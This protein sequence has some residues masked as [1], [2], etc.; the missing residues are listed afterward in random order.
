TLQVG[1]GGTTGTL[2]G[3][4]VVNNGALVF[5]RSN[6]LAV[7]NAISGSGSLTQAG[8]GLLTLSGGNSYG[9][10]T[11]VSGTGGLTL[12]GGSA[13]GNGSAVQVDA[14][15][16]LTIDTSETIGSL[17]GAGTV[18]LAT[19]QALSTGGNNAS[20]LFSGS[21]TGSVTVANT[22]QLI[23]QGS[24]SFTLTG[25]NS[26]AGGTSIAAG[27]SL[28]LGNGGTTGSLAGGAITNDGTLIVDRSN[29][30][31][32]AN[33]IGGSGALR[34]AGAGLL[35]L[36]ADNSYGGGTTIDTGSTLQ[37]GNGGAGG[38]AG[39][40]PID[41]DGA[42]VVNR[43]ADL[44]LASLLQGNG[45]LTQTGSGLLTLTAD[46][47]YLDTTIDSGSTL[48]V[49]AGGSTGTLGSGGITNNG[50]LVFDR[51]AAVTLAGAMTGTGALVQTGSGLLILGADNSHGGGTTIDAGSTLQVGAGGATG[52]LGSGPV[53]NQG[54]LVFDRSAALTVANT[55]SGAGTL[56]QTGS[57]SL[58]LAAD[59]SYGGGTTIDSGSVLRLGAGGTTGSAGSGAIVDNGLLVVERSSALVLGMAISGSGGL[60][61]AGTGQLTLSGSN[62]YSGLTTVERGTLRLL[63][64][65]ALADTA[66]VQLDA[67]AT[68][69]LDAN[70]TIGSLSG[71][72]GATV[73]LGLDR[74]L[75]LGGNNA[76]TVFAGSI[77]G[78]TSAPGTVQL[79]KL[80][81]GRFTLAG[82]NS[83]AGGITVADG[84]LQVGNGGTAGS[85]GSGPVG[86]NAA[87]VFDRSDAAGHVVANSITGS[88][89][90]TQAGTGRLILTG[91]NTYGGLTTVQ[92]GTTLQVGQG[93]GT[94]ALG[95]GNV[96]NQGALVFDRSTALTVSGRI[97]G[98]GT[99]TQ[100]GGGML[101]LSGSNGY[102][103][104]TTVLSGGLT[105]AGG[106]ALADSAAVQLADAA[107]ATLV[108]A[109]DETLGSLAGGGAAG[110][111]V[112]L[113]SH[114]LTLGGGTTFG[115]RIVGTGGLT[116]TGTDLL[117]LAGDSSYSGPTTIAA[118]VLQVGDGGSTGSL[119]SGSV[120]NQGLLRF[121]R[122]NALLV[123]NDISGSGGLTQAGSGTLTLA[124]ANT[125]AG[126][127]LVAAGVLATQGAE[128]LPDAGAVQV[129]NGAQ[130]QLGGN[131]AIGSLADATGQ[132]ADGSARVLLGSFTLA[133]G[134]ASD[135]RF[136]GVIDGS[137]GFT[138]TGS[139]RFTLAGLNSYTG[140]TLVAAGTLA[141]EG[142]SA[143]HL[144][145]R[146]ALQIANGAVLALG[147]AETVASLADADGQA[148]DGSAR[149][150]LGTHTLT[151]GDANSTVYTGQLVGS[152]GAGRLVK[153][154][155]G[156]F[157][158]AQPGANSHGGTSVLDG[159]LRLSSDAQLGVAGAGLLLDGGSLRVDN[160]F[161][162]AAGRV[163]TLQGAGGTIDVA[164]GQTLAYEGGTADGSSAGR[165]TKTG[166]GTLL[167]AGANG[168]TGLTRIEA[169]TLAT[170]AAQR[171]SDAGALQLANG[172]VLVLGG[173]ETIASLADL[174]GLQADGSAQ[175]ALGAHTLTTGDAT[176]TVFSG[177]LDGVGGLTKLGSGR[178]TLA[179]AQAYTG[180]TLVEAGTLATDAADRL[181][182]ATRVQIANGAML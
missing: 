112:D 86:N 174:A 160:S 8:T 88:G 118:G 66:A 68:L 83:M 151:L 113:R 39:S 9:G 96:L 89:T 32:L 131:E 69:V 127:T 3:G 110:G 43:S 163:I 165:L 14:G 27:G 22:L 40:G 41:L 128:R 114:T 52:T 85:L 65:N 111:G 159:V 167:L 177:R 95:S 16:T 37:L 154:G 182:D 19:D 104:L 91:D 53:V 33:S 93:G 143:G 59:N 132:V 26:Y 73:A 28:Q 105:L 57:G 178:F 173:D 107:G 50:S 44:T 71:A 72:A 67:G 162:L 126:L 13:I 122:G 48:R 76:S 35:T 119:G 10:G 55:I 98:S 133:A 94:G 97:D 146:S 134:D 2:G 136:G 51:S 82:D 30:I 29:A 62:S 155:S 147:G 31:T 12:Q 99:L 54:S 106:A 100:Q 172:A 103:G 120:L 17:A 56:R 108:L 130:L 21:I 1:N 45:S 117:V 64:G 49:G 175:V 109:D 153:Q 80:G 70:E 179:G 34:Q 25:S 141:T 47:T 135:T 23:K 170:G 74:R 152:G 84:T 149:L 20:T 181:A 42:L 156:M 77:T 123:A 124:G 129:A 101:T 158:L 92:A 90:L 6:A 78:S 18:A 171:L 36:T 142:G 5:N 115:G 116:K 166:G 75:T 176:D 61:Q 180:L 164:A 46:N 24:G 137:G 58:T 79:V 148:A 150:L 161:A 63:G 169:G 60:T 81:S 11:T 125:Y 157:T 138:K 7:G 144:D 145:D 4:A 121:Q 168:H 38:T 87:L 140:L 15:T 139:G 102:T